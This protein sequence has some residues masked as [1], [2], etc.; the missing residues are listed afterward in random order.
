MRTKIS[1]E[2]AGFFY[3]KKGDKEEEGF[4]PCS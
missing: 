4:S 3:K 1:E 2:N